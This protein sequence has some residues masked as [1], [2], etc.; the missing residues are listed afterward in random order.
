MTYRFL[1]AGL[2]ATACF[3]QTALPAEVKAPAEVETALRARVNEF[4]SLL[5]KKDFRR[6][7]ALIAEDTKDYYYGIAKPDFVKYE[8]LEIHFTDLTHAIAT[9]QCAQKVTQPG[10][11]MGEWSLK[12]P[13]LWKLENGN[14]FWYINQNETMTPVGIVQRKDGAVRAPE[15]PAVARTIPKDIPTSA[16]FVMGKVVLDRNSVVLDGEKPEKI[17]VA[18]GSA[19]EIRLVLP[20]QLGLDL[21]LAP[22]SLK[23]GEKAVLTVHANKKSVSGKVFI[24]IVPTQEVLAFDVTLK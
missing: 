15:A 2:V 21:N 4:Y 22:T 17:I 7:E 14:W 5:L 9:T 11:P 24:Q 10:F 8:L 18:N 16:E 19:G 3:A 20:G 12:V 1:L 23:E 6:A 13:S